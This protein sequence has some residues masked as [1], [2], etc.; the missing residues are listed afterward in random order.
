M[1]LKVNVPDA[2]EEEISAWQDG[3]GYELKVKQTGSGTFD[4]VEAEAGEAEETEAEPEVPES[5]EAAAAKFT[6]RED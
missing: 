6:E 5:M 4:L 2:M 3:M 1:T